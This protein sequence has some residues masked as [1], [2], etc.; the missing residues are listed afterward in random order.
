MWAA[1]LAWVEG[2]GQIQGDGNQP[3][4]VCPRSLQRIQQDAPSQKPLAG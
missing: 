2:D 1:A 3:G 4:F